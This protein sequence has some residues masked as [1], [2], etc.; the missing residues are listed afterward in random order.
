MRYHIIKASRS[1]DGNPYCGPSSDNLPAE[2]DTLAEAIEW[3]E[4]LTKR[5]PAG[6]V[7]VEIETGRKLEIVGG[8]YLVEKF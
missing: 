7:I 1:Y 4:R 2:A 5:N 6:W 8:E 3:V